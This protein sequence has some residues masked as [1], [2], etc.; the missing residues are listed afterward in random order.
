MNAADPLLTGPEVAERIGIGAATWRG[1]VSRGHAPQPDDPDDGRPIN[2][3]RPR[4][5]TS[6]VDHFALNRPG[7]G[8]RTDH[9]RKQG[10]PD[11]RHT[12]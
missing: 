11:D 3:R 2:R 9:T 5:L 1:Y 6:T 4:W 10:L 8:A 12:Y 7:Q